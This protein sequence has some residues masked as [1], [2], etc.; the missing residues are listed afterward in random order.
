MFE[1]LNTIFKYKEKES[2]D[3]MGLFPE[4]VH[5]GA[6]PERRYLWTSR[7]L[8]IMAS[9]S[10]CIS[11]MLIST[12]YLLLPQKTAYPK[13]FY[14]NRF[15]NQ[16]EQVQPSEIN[17]PVGD[18]ITE[19][20]I[21]EYIMLRYIITNDYDEIRSRWDTGSRLYWYSSSSVWKEFVETDLENS[22]MQFR[23]EGLVRSVVIDWI[24][25]LA[26][27]VWFTQF[28]TFDYRSAQEK[29]KV[30]IWRATMRVI[31]VPIPFKNRDDA[32]INPFG[33]MVTNF[34]LAYHGTPETSVHYLEIAR[35]LAESRLR[36]EHQQ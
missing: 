1:I 29:P 4:T 15:F 34:S 32:I 14:I 10:V 3:K 28:R 5:I 35:Q 13:L 26:R 6:M 8:V 36:I 20:H 2:P 25:P 11:M 17:F 9:I 23:S 24:R 30:N 18:L 7:L 19:M 16:L 12:I 27:N 31:Y 22:I 21:Y 33:F